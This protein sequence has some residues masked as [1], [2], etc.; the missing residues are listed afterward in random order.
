[1]KN[2]KLK[3]ILSLCILTIIGCDDDFLEEKP[4]DTLFANTLFVN[5]DG[6]QQ[7]LNALYS[8]VR[9]ERSE[10]A[11][12]SF[13]RS[14]AWKA[15]T[16]VA[17]GNYTFS[18]LRAVD[19]YGTNLNSATS[20][21]DGLFNWLY[22][23]VVAANQIIARAE[24]G[25][26][27]FQG[28]NDVENLATQNLMVAQARLLRAWAYRHLTN[29]WGDVPLNIQEIDGNN[30]R[31][32]WERSEVSIIQGQMIED[33]TFAEQFLP[34]SYDDPLV[35]SNAVAKHYLSELYLLRGENSLAEQKAEEVISNP[36]FALITERFGVNM[37]EPGVPFMDQ[38]D[39]GNSLPSGG[40]T[41]T[42][43]TFL[44]AP[45]VPGTAST[46]MRRTW[47]NRYF[48]LTDDD[49]WAFSE[50][51][52]RGIGRTAHTRY[53]EGLY[54]E[55]DDRFGR[56]AF[57]RFYL[58]E[59]AGDTIFTRVPSF[60][61]WKTSDPAWPGTKKW[62]GFPDLPRVNAA[63]QTNSMP[64]LRLAETYLIAA[65]AEFNQGK[66]GEAAAHINALRVR[67]NATP[68]TAGD[69]TQDYILDERARELFS[70]EHRRY[71]LNRMG[72]LVER[73]LQHNKFS[74]ITERDILF[75]I[76]QN[77]IDSNDGVTEQNPGY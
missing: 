2:I 49:I 72:R 48:N 61:D 40:N 63:E 25:T 12:V 44:N 58:T 10:L 21:I 13:E 51:G 65:E 37:N 74:Q 62:D 46:A 15:G 9:E 34:D 7:G 27:D 67:S 1:M 23:V 30:F 43:W 54:E 36:N 17:W 4:Q 24:S 64:Y 70:E 35:L 75:P 77:F 60:D 29:S 32:F 69:I 28:A 55:Q 14:T 38:F 71:T 18:S 5:R 39:E 16:D 50:Y 56:F 57:S 8:L 22:E 52:G 6:L 42:L 11:G 59:E 68:I 20:T 47:V 73:T 19:L 66:N 45:D 3:M 53:V 76:P 33:L 41:E 26:I 31:T